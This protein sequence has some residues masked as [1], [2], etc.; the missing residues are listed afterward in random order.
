[1]KEFIIMCGKVALG[2]FIAG[3]LILGSDTNEEDSLLR[4]SKTV[5]QDSLEFQKNYP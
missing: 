2:I 3:V 5:M 1:M 4:K